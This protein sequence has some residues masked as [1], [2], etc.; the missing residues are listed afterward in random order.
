MA[1]IQ[2]SDPVLEKVQEHPSF[3]LLIVVSGLVVD[4]TLGLLVWLTWNVILFAFWFMNFNLGFIFLAL[5]GAHLA[6]LSFKMVRTDELG[7]FYFFGKLLKK[8]GQGLHYAPWPISMEIGPRD[9]QQVWAPGKRNDIYWGDE[10]TAL[11]EGMVRPIFMNTRAPRDDEK[12][13]LDVQMTVGF[14]YALFWRIIDLPEFL[15]HSRTPEEVSDQLRSISEAVLAEEIE[16]LTVDGAITGQRKINQKFDNTIRDRTKNWGIEVVRANLTQI[17]PSHELAKAM[18]DR[19]EAEFTAQNTVIAGE[20]DRKASKARTLGPIEAKTEGLGE[21]MDRLKV[22]GDA[23]L[24]SDT[25]ER[26]I[27]D[28]TIIVGTQ[29]ITDLLGLVKAGQAALK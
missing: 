9:V 7:A 25:L 11:P 18:R 22:S 13:P 17:N 27:P 21:L 10:K 1:E 2:D 20:A 16:D 3:Y 24:A 26:T 14:A 12:K 28:K 6:L 15:A 4:V 23:V 8:A 5:L 29:G 19:A